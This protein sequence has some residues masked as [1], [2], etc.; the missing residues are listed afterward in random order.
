M[1]CSRTGFPT[2]ETTSKDANSKLWCRCQDTEDAWTIGVSTEKAQ[3][4]AIQKAVTSDAGSRDG[5]AGLIKP[6]RA[7]M[8]PPRVQMLHMELQRLAFALLGLGVALA[9]FFLVILPI[10]FGMGMFV[11]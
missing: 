9:Q 6:F 8:M 11:L 1:I 7:Q 2:R 10:I 5:G 4:G 3:S